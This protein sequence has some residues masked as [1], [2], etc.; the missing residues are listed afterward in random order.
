MKKLTRVAAA[1][2]AGWLM[3]MAASADPSHEHEMMMA[4]AGSPALE[5]MKQ[6]AGAWESPTPMGKDG[7][8]TTVEYQVTAGGSVVAER[9]APGT[10][11]EM[12]TVYYDQGGKLRM[13]HYCAMG[14]HPSMALK[15]SDATKL[16]FDLVPGSVASPQEGHMH[17]LVI[18]TPSPD[19]LVQA[20]TFYEK[21]KPTGTHTFEFTRKP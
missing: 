8:K 20:W 11:G 21:G 13:T 4:K 6:L 3:A 5:R 14:N 12:L 17:A 16:E 1:A 19:K 15:S 2:F 18:S 9:L 7:G 10:P